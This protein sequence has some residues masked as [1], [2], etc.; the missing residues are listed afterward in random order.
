MLTLERR[1]RASVPIKLGAHR[2]I[3]P[4]NERLRQF[5]SSWCARTQ[6]TLSLL[7]ASQSEGEEV[8]EWRC[9]L[10]SL[11]RGKEHDWLPK[12]LSSKEGL[13]RLQSFLRSCDPGTRSLLS[14]AVRGD[15]DAHLERFSKAAAADA[16]ATRS[17][18]SGAAE[19]LNQLYRFLGGTD[20][21]KRIEFALGKFDLQLVARRAA[22]KARL[23]WEPVQLSSRIAPGL[24]GENYDPGRP[25]WWTGK[26]NDAPEMLGGK[27]TLERAEKVATALE[28]S[29]E[30]YLNQSDVPKPSW[31]KVTL[32]NTYFSQGREPRVQFGELKD[33]PGVEGYLKKKPHGGPRVLEFPLED[34][35]FAYL[36]FD[37][38]H[39]AAAQVLRGHRRFFHLTVMRLGEVESHYG[40]SAQEIVEAIRD[41][42]THLY[43]TDEPVPR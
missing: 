2:T 29:L 20:L 26:L 32:E 3:K 10:E 14:Q 21:S 18:F 22:L 6:V 5:V 23:N 28:R 16:R 30:R 11:G 31:A 34:G 8:P 39:R 43:M 4:R 17:E 9:L 24:R 37:G 40:L 36:M 7:A 38:H 41:L 15:I 13:D 42:H 35:S 19:A 33:A 27:L 25:N 1:E 12:L